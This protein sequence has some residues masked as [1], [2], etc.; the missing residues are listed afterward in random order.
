M[1]NLDENGVSGEAGGQK[2][3]QGQ[4]AGQPGSNLPA[5][6]SESKSSGTGQSAW[7]VK[8]ARPPKFYRI[9][10]IVEFSGFSRQ[11]IHN[12]T[13]MGLLNEARR[14]AGDHRLYDETVFDRLG[15]ISQLKAQKRSLKQIREFLLNNP[16]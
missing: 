13:S 1:A 16:G 5:G 4:S 9:G 12:Y 14:S 3:Q 15:L 6:A 10:E 8:A 11:T 7:Q 2:D